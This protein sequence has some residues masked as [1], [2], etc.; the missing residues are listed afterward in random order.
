MTKQ[1]SPAAQSIYNAAHAADSA[2]FSSL[3]DVIAA[4]LRA[5]AEPFHWTW[6]AEM[7]HKHL[8]TIAQELETQ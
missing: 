6:N 2:P 4:A 5:V 8:I 3:T 7:C 1:L